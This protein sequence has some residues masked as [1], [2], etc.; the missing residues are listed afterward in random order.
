MSTQARSSKRAG[1]G[2]NRGSLN[3][4]ITVLL[5]ESTATALPKFPKIRDIVIDANTTG[6]VITYVWD[7]AGWR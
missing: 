2:S 5:S 3:P 1:I 7:G 6:S 4:N